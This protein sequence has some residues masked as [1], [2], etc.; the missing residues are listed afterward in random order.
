MLLCWDRISPVVSFFRRRCPLDS[1]ATP[2]PTWTS[3]PLANPWS[4]L[5]LPRAGLPQSKFQLG[6]GL[7]YTLW[8]MPSHSTYPSTQGLPVHVVRPWI[9]V[10]ACVSLERSPWSFITW[11]LVQR[12][13]LSQWLPHLHGR[14]LA[15]FVLV[16]MSSCGQSST[17]TPPFIILQQAY[18]STDSV[19]VS[20]RASGDFY[21]PRIYHHNNH[22]VIVCHFAR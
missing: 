3:Y 19:D 14:P 9:S 11:P 21:L 15:W 2:P 6:A 22:F 10:I 5:Y 13:P 18:A 17:Y 8:S 16:S 4:V 20:A 1:T 12:V 7:Q